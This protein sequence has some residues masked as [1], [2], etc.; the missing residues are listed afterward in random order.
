MDSIR[1]VEFEPRVQR[2]SRQM[3]I[4]FVNQ[5]DVKCKRPRQWASSFPVVPTNCVAVH[6]GGAKQLEYCFRLCEKELK[7]S[8]SNVKCETFDM[9]SRKITFLDAS[10]TC[11][12]VSIT[13][14]VATNG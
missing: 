7:G 1:V 9:M 2:E 11:W 10:P 14:D 8:S 13:S 4:N 5:L 12:V 3:A 6:G